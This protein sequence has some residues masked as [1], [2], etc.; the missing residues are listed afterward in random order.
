MRGRCS[1]SA[2]CSPATTACAQ[3][4]FSF[5]DYFKEEAILYAWNFVTQELGLPQH[6]LRVTVH[7]DDEESAALWKKVV[8]LPAAQLTRPCHASW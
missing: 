5:G 2:R 7:H 1:A 8:R 3:G 6:K 4:N